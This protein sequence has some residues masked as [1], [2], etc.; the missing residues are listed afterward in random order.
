MLRLPLLWLCRL[1]CFDTRPVVAAVAVGVAF[2]GPLSGIR[3]FGTESLHRGPCCL[4]LCRGPFAET[5]FCFVDDT[6]LAVGIAATDEVVVAAVAIVVA[7]PLV[8]S[9]IDLGGGRSKCTTSTYGI[10]G[11]RR[12][13]NK[14]NADATTNSRTHT[15]AT[16]GK[17]L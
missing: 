6:L 5:D 14:R 17:V 10:R 16:T 11:T 15:T 1:H 8:V 7:V 9:T 13:S 4:F 12:P 2:S 3:L